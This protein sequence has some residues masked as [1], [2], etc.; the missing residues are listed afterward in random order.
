M[1]KELL[2][3]A[4]LGTLIS[5]PVYAAPDKSMNEGMAESG[6]A[7]KVGAKDMRQQAKKSGKNL[8]DD[9]D[10]TAENAEQK[11]K[12]MIEQG[13]DA[14]HDAADDANEAAETGKEKADK[15]VP[16]GMA[17]R[18]QHPSTGKGSEQGQ[19]SRKAEEKSWWNFWE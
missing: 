16:P 8:S 1:K 3:A 2:V 19:A 18:D 4:F 5:V 14:A 11:A 12:D 15:A 6:K 7:A 13:E 17:K 10:E 9:I